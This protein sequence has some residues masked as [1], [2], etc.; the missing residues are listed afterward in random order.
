MATNKHAI[1]R[2][3]ALDKC[4]SNWGR[5]YFIDDLIDAC[6]LALYE[7]SGNNDG[8]KRRQIFEDIKFMESEQGYAIELDKQKDG[9]KV[10]Y[11]YL[12]KKFSINNSPI[13][14]TEA[15]Y[16]KNVV[17]ILQRFEGAPGFEWISEM[18][19]MLSDQFG[20]KDSDKK[21]MSYDSNIDYSGYKHIT[22]IFN[23]IV[24]KRVLSVQYEPFGKPIFEFEFHPYFLKQYN[25]RWFVFGRNNM[26]EIT[27]WNMPLDRVV[28][29]NEVDGNYV[30]DKTDWEEFF[31]DFIGVT[32]TDD[33]ITEVK[34]LF[35]KSQAPY[36][37]TKPLHETQKTN[38]LED[39]SLE[40]RIKV[41]SNYE[42]ETMLLGFGEKVKIISP[43]TLTI[44]VKSRLENAL[45]QY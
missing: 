35:T 19:S 34:L 5:K 41:I 42:L 23:A 13:N 28:S 36:V 38:L 20:L 22:P 27:H 9:R 24:N 12:D 31:A 37:L 6:N 3:Q 44:A 40:V 14:T 39:G 1:I 32:K 43:S 30:E 21:V 8:V 29:I 4:F 26:L 25:N 15:E 10:Y 33:K 11:R 45:K 18:S 17:S 2:Y 7:Y 16:L